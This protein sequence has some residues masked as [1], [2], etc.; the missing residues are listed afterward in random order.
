MEHNAVLARVEEIAKA[1]AV[2]AIDQAR[3]YKDPVASYAQNVRDTLD[4]T[5]LGS[6]KQHGLKVY[7]AR[8]SEL[9]PSE[10]VLENSDWKV[11]IRAD[12][13]SGWFEY[14]GEAIGSLIFGGLP[15]GQTELTDHDGTF[16]LPRKVASLLR[17]AGIHVDSTFMMQS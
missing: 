2:A 11:T 10:E 5:G 17:E 14:K 8:V 6:Y 9:L 16:E 7:Y 3:E 13:M 15:G 12:R 4:E 1:N